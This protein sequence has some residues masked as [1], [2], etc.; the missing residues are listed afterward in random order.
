VNQDLLRFVARGRAASEAGADAITWRVRGRPHISERVDTS[1][2]SA[3]YSVRF[4]LHNPTSRAITIDSAAIMM[5]DDVLFPLSRYAEHRIDAR[6]FP[7]HLAAGRSESFDFRPPEL[8]NLVARH[9]G[10]GTVILH[11][12]C[13]YDDERPVKGRPMLF[14]IRL[15]N[16]PP[17]K[18]S[19]SGQGPLP[20]GWT[21]LSD[22]YPVV[23]RVRRGGLADG[24]LYLTLQEMLAIRQKADT[25]DQPGS[26]Y[27]G[28][29]I[30]DFSMW[31]TGD[32]SSGGIWRAVMVL[33]DKTR[34]ELVE[35]RD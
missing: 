6:R 1:G 30:I 27:R 13:Q 3:A 16:S 22:R 15:A 23:Q 14:D 31:K 33:A 24:V 5:G 8:A 9:G 10:R 35:D 25:R 26:T 20:R 32:V 34:L 4:T 29:P 7:L 12:V 18:G 19:L 17:F 11:G 21:W 28:Q 2:A